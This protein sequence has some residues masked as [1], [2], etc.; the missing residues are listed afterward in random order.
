MARS[1]STV[2]TPAEKK[3]MVRAAKVELK[4]SKE[5]VKDITGRAKAIAKA[6][7]DIVKAWGVEDKALTK[8]AAA[9]EKAVAATAARIEALTAA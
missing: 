4:A 9:A 7:K 3:E 6:R 1:A 2:V 5:V 8:E